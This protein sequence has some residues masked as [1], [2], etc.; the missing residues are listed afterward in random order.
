[1]PEG[2]APVERL[3]NF[4]LQT[5]DGADFTLSDYLGK[6]VVLNLW[7]TWCAPCVKELPSFD[8]LYQTY[9]DSVVVLAIHSSL[10]TEDVSAYLAD[11]DYSL[12]FAIDEADEV[13]PLLGG[14]TMLPQTIVVSPAGVVTYNK[15][16][17]VSYELLESIL[18]EAALSSSSP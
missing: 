5:L 16:G 9:S 3:P 13:I 4:T 12:P 6:T 2:H 8:R 18:Q 14:S 7:A 11:F 1:M 10:I 17:S 15:V